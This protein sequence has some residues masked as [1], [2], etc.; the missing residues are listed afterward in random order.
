[1]TAV[2]AEVEPHKPGGLPGQKLPDQTADTVDGAGAG[3]AV[4][5]GKVCRGL[6]WKTPGGGHVDRSRANHCFH[7]WRKDVRSAVAED[8]K[9]SI[10][11]RDRREVAAAAQNEGLETEH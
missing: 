11:I 5:F 4:V 9:D 1:M 10:R 7:L 6:D 3:L 8:G 2:A